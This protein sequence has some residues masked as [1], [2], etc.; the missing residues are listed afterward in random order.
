LGRS[1]TGAVVE[2]VEAVKIGGHPVEQA[3]EFDDLV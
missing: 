3:L 2:G 1:F